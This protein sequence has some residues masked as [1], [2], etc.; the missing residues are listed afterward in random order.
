MNSIPPFC[1]YSAP[2]RSQTAQGVYLSYSFE[3]C[4]DAR[5]ISGNL[6]ELYRQG[7]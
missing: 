3:Y 2:G 6:R 1:G 5:G 7:F 4:F